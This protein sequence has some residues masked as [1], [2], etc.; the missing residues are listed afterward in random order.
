MRR[1][2]VKGCKSIFSLCVRISASI[3]KDLHHCWGLT[4]PHRPVKGCDSIFL[5]CV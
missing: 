4:K 3:Q 5:P 1:R 2:Q